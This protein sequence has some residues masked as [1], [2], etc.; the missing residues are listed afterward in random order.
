MIL[1]RFHAL[2][3]PAHAYT[4]EN[5]VIIP[6]QTHDPNVVITSI[7]AF[8]TVRASRCIISPQKSRSFSITHPDVYARSNCILGGFIQWA[9]NAVESTFLKLIHKVCTKQ[10]PRFIKWF[11]T[12]NPRMI[13][14]I[15]S[16]RSNQS[17]H[18]KTNMSMT[19]MH[20]NSID[21]TGSNIVLSE[22]HW[23]PSPTADKRNSDQ[24]ESLKQPPAYL[25]SAFVLHTANLQGSAMVQFV[26]VHPEIL[27]SLS[28]P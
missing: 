17:D 23:K 7:A 22:V 9:R 6:T 16:S 12:I 18:L 5:V 24:D 8:L 14:E 28:G 27:Q 10:I 13:R 4:V 25:A 2:K 21:R 20:I 11:W 3:L 26:S 1:C 19:D 15:E